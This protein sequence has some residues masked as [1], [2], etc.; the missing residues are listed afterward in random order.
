MGKKT[1]SSLLRNVPHILK[2]HDLG[3]LSQGRCSQCGGCGTG[4][5]VARCHI[6]LGPRTWSCCLLASGNPDSSRP[7]MALA[8]CVISES[9][10]FLSFTFLLCERSIIKVAEQVSQL[11]FSAEQARGSGFL[12]C[13]PTHSLLYPQFFCQRSLGADDSEQGDPSAGSA[14]PKSP[15]GKP[16]ILEPLVVTFLSAS[17]ARLPMRLSMIALMG[18]LVLGNARS[19]R[20]IAH[21]GTAMFFTV[22]EVLLLSTEAFPAHKAAQRSGS[23]EVT[24]RSELSGAH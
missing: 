8:S 7:P 21:Q 9:R 22:L 14:G 17:P 10:I 23:N 5:E 12:P 13:F 2:A 4:P 3:R 18:L 6:P 24:Q 20:A 19:G 11:D 1:K 16:H 15:R